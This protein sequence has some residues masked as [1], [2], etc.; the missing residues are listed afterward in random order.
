[1]VRI[2]SIPEFMKCSCKCHSIKHI[3]MDRSVL[4]LFLVDFSLKFTA[5]SLELNKQMYLYS[6]HKPSQGSCYHHSPQLSKCCSVSPAVC[7][8][9]GKE[10]SI[11]LFCIL[12]YIIGIWHVAQ[13]ET[14]CFKVKQT[15]Q[16]VLYNWNGKWM[17][18]VMTFS[19]LLLRNKNFQVQKSCLRTF[20][21][22]NEYFSKQPRNIIS[23]WL[24]YG[25]PG[26]IIHDC[27]QWRLTQLFSL[28]IFFFF[29]ILLKNHYTCIM[30]TLNTNVME[31]EIV[32]LWPCLGTE[33]QQ[34]CTA[35]SPHKPWQNGPFCHLNIIW[36]IFTSKVPLG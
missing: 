22:V 12:Y 5:L 2:F 7:L 15:F 20:F 23:Q 17:D 9:N 36:H 25:L 1:M 35:H 16:C 32:L 3:V 14:K 19:Y 13:E 4:I 34:L 21:W 31:S 8:S 10:P 6:D 11:H 24:D 30:L 27:I 26:V 33:T 29:L 28:D 18:F